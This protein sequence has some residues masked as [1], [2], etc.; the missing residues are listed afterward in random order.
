MNERNG[1]KQKISLTMT[2]QFVA[3]IGCLQLVKHE[4]IG[5]NILFSHRL[6]ANCPIGVHLPHHTNPMCSVRKISEIPVLLSENLRSQSVHDEC[7]NRNSQIYEPNDGEKRIFFINFCN[8]CNIRTFA[9]SWIFQFK[10]KIQ[11]ESLKICTQVET[12]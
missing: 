10:E 12:A 5:K 11:Q 4:K 9:F 7:W 3:V 2:E 1:I 8:F 6:D